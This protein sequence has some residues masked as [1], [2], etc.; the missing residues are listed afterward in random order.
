M[1]QESLLVMSLNVVFFFLCSAVTEL[2]SRCSMLS[3]DWL[4]IPE[5]IATC[6]KLLSCLSF[7]SHRDL[8]A[9]D[10][11]SWCFRCVC[12]TPM[13]KEQHGDVNDR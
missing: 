3:R 7:P 11:K 4:E 2:K 9:C 1:Q 13:L 5:V 12:W 8:S 10:T 6:L